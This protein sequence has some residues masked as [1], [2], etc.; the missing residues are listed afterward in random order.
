MDHE[1]PHSG[2][3]RG[4]GAVSKDGSIARMATKHLSSESEAGFDRRVPMSPTLSARRKPS[5]AG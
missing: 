3:R 2:S 4:E 5:I 1:A